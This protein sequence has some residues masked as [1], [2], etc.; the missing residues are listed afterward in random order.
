[1]A[2]QL[3]ILQKVKRNGVRV[4]EREEALHFVICSSLLLEMNPVG[5][6]RFKN[7]FLPPTPTPRRLSAPNSKRFVSDREKSGVTSHVA[8]IKTMSFSFSL[9]LTPSLLLPMLEDDVFQ[10]SALLTLLAGPALVFDQR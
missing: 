1:M 7:L 2:I 6:R 8:A 9:L 5:T 3:L 4:V 10:M